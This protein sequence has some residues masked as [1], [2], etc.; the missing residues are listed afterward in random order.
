MTAGLGE[1]LCNSCKTHLHPTIST[2]YDGM[3]AKIT[4]YPKQRYHADQTYGYETD[5]YDWKTEC[6]AYFE[7]FDEDVDEDYSYN[8]S[9]AAAIL[10]L[11]VLGALF[12]KRRRV[13]CSCSEQADENTDDKQDV[14]S[15]FEKMGPS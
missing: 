8:S 14:N 6:W 1:A 5:E 11:G 13:S 3:T 12:A 4:L 7:L 2:G 10:C 9:A 15:N